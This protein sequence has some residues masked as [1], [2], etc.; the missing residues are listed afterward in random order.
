MWK[1][2]IHFWKSDN[3]LKQALDQSFEMLDIDYEMFQAAVKSLRHT[4]MGVDDAT[5][6]KDKIV[7]KYEREVRRKVITHLSVS[8]TSDLPAGLVLTTI[9]I[10]IE[11][12]GDYIKNILDLASLHVPKLQVGN[13]IDQLVHVEESVDDMFAKSITCFKKSDEALALKLM[14]ETRTIGKTCDE[15]IEKLI[16]DEHPSLAPGDAVAMALYLR[17]LK[18]INAHLRNITSS[19]VN[20]FDRIG[21][22]Y[23]KKA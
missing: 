18:R 10:D 11:R 8:G 19:I 4:D 16:K 17:Y 5:R 23:K 22:K 6:A 20:P 12:I 13:L 3:L 15:M 2:L 21:F 14:A 9:I 1:G 7:N